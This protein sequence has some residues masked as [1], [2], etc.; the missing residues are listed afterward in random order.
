MPKRVKEP[1]VETTFDH[2]NSE[3][4]EVEDLQATREVEIQQRIDKAV[5]AALAKAQTINTKD[6][7]SKT[8]NITKEDILSIMAQVVPAAIMAMETAKNMSGHEAK[9]AELKRKMNLEEK[10]HICRQVVGDGKGRGCG[11]PWKRD[12]QGN[13]ILE[14]LPDGLE[15]RVEDAD[16]FHERMVVYPS[17]PIA[18]QQWDGVQ[19]NGAFYRS[20]GP[21]HKV[22]VPKQNDIASQI[23][24]FTEDQ[25]IQAT[26]RKKIRP[27]SGSISG[28]GSQNLNPLT[29]T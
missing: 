12:K 27:N 9:L 17:H 10:C 4:P 22:W 11:G 23:L 29:F 16:Q 2:S 8:S 26:G 25:L 14:T 3:A 24:K 7:G 28:N 21:N 18:E 6:S 15:R 19:I 20:Q 1:I 13:Y 5:E